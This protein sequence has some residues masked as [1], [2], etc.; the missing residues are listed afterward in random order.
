[1]NSSEKA[2]GAAKERVES[3][4]SAISGQ[5]AA[6]KQAEIRV[7]IANDNLDF[8]LIVAPIDGIV[9]NI[10][11]KVGD[12]LEAGD[13]LTSITQDDAL[14]LSVSVPLEQTEELKIG[15]PVEVID[16]QGKA[17]AKGDVSFISPK[18]DRSSQAVLV[19]AALNNNGR[20]KDDSFA[21]AKIIWSEK[22]GVLIPTETVSRI[23]GKSFVFVAEEKEQKD[24]FS[25]LV[26]VQKPVTLGAIQGQSYQV[27]SGLELGDRLITTGILNLANNTPI[28][29]KKETVT[30]QGIDE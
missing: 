5:Q 13:Q 19:K 8:N 2:L 30:T 20:L 17:I 18:V 25:K 14:E 12:Y 15:L 27:I 10:Q 28:N 9:G 11:S 24:G 29:L 22:T 3:A 16:F 23:A 1:M 21:R 26:A 6:L 7:N 4:R